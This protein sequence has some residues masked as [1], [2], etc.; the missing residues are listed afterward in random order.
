MPHAHTHKYIHPYIRTYIHTNVD[1]DKHCYIQA[2]TIA[3]I[4]TDRQTDGQTDRQ[5]DG[6]TD[7]QQ[8]KIDAG[9]NLFGHKRAHT[10]THKHKH[11]HTHTHAH[12][13]AHVR[14]HE[15]R[16]KLAH[17]QSTKLGTT[18]ASTAKIQ[19]VDTVGPVD[20]ERLMDA[21]WTQRDDPSLMHDMT[22]CQSFYWQ[23]ICCRTT[24]LNTV[25]DHSQFA[26]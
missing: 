12:P 7:R 14:H 16:S 25:Q 26:A 20:K 1:L 24:T 10:C 15:I 19:A 22:A 23:C 6:Q 18:T 2:R 8:V 5:T 3:Y 17:C 21:L 4:Q 13:R 9:K 11:T